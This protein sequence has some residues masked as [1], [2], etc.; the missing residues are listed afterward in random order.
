[1]AKAIFIVQFFTKL[2]YFILTLLDM[3][4]ICADYQKNANSIL[5][6]LVD[7]LSALRT[8]FPILGRAQDEPANHLSNHLGQT[9]ATKDGCG[10]T[11]TSF[12]H[13][14]IA[15]QFRKVHSWN[16]WHPGWIFPRKKN[17]VWGLEWTKYHL[18]KV[19]ILAYVRQQT[20]ISIVD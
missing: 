2:N 10:L 16:A 6:L 5:P 17:T 1:M 7:L 15:C 14:K 8:P 19:I 20:L 4:S 3:V 9:S 11:S 13:F 12:T 18:D